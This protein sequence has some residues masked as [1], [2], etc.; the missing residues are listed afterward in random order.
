MYQI[1]EDKPTP[2]E[3]KTDRPCKIVYVGKKITLDSRHIKNFKNRY[4]EKY[5]KEKRMIQ[6]ALGMPSLHSSDVPPNHETGNTYKPYVY[7]DG[8]VVINGSDLTVNIMD[9]KTQQKSTY[10]NG[11]VTALF[12]G[13]LKCKLVMGKYVSN[14]IDV[15]KEYAEQQIFY[16]SFLKDYKGRAQ[17]TGAIY[18]KTMN[19]ICKSIFDLCKNNLKGIFDDEKDTVV[20][21]NKDGAKKKTREKLS[22]RILILPDSTQNSI[23][24][25]KKPNQS[26]MGTDSF[27]NKYSSIPSSVHKSATYATIDDMAY[28]LNPTNV[29]KKASEL[30]RYWGSHPIIGNETFKKIGMN[31]K[32]DFHFLGGFMWYFGNHAIKFARDRHAQDDGTET[33]GSYKGSFKHGIWHQ[34]HEGMEQAELAGGSGSGMVVLCVKKLNIARIEIILS[35]SVT[36]AS[37][38]KSLLVNGVA[39]KKS[40]F[41]IRDTYCA[42]EEVLL[43][44]GKRQ[45]ANSEKKPDW[46]L[47]MEAVANILDGKKMD[48]ERLVRHIT[49][50]F[51]ERYTIEMWKLVKNKKKAA[52]FLDKAKFVISTLPIPHDGNV[53]MD[54]AE[55]YAYR[56][57][58]LVG[59]YAKFNGVENLI[60]LGLQP[61]TRCDVRTLRSIFGDIALKLSLSKRGKDLNAAILNIKLQM[62]SKEPSSTD[63]NRDLTLHFYMGLFREL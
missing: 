49:F 2:S 28:M 63:K 40:D 62:P 56:M 17:I 33:I 39:L 47:Y 32:R 36:V 22:F 6:D 5:N 50:K 48:R 60:E 37:L 42:M 14:G 13:D 53:E 44:E 25:H 57:G 24:K 27:Q 58:R 9:S 3:W 16:T 23:I 54:Y 46:S 18:E 30:V 34:L 8:E 26:V 4:P 7:I 31:L 55:E 19:D 35:E 45:G 15:G 20:E 11:K 12:K 29:S 61:G 38:Q 10:E 21:L 59:T 51:R 43:K 1:N 41:S 52:L